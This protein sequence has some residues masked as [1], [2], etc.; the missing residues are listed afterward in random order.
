M[1]EKRGSFSEGKKGGHL[2][3]TIKKGSFS[4][5]FTGFW[6]KKSNLARLSILVPKQTPICIW[7]S[8]EV[9]IQ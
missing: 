7:A 5:K 4:V 2:V 1:R 6:T 8:K 9:V 3:R